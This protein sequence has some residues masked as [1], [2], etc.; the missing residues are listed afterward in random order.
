MNRYRPAHIVEYGVLRV[1][2]AFL[3]ALPY[4]AALTTA[5]I[6]AGLT[7]W[8]FQFRRREALRR[9]RLVLGDSVS[10]RKVRSIA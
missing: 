8:V 5:W 9:I 6:L 2:A 10:A 7:H 1:Q 4:R 3:N